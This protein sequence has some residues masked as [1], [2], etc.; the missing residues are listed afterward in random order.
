MIIRSKNSDFETN[1]PLAGYSV[2]EKEDKLLVVVGVENRISSMT[3]VCQPANS[4]F[5][6][7]FHNVNYLEIA[8]L[9]TY[10]F[11]TLDE[12]YQFNENY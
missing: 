7:I 9:N 8:Y 11:I 3:F 2:I 10:F 6:K 12:L 4:P 1:I 5:S